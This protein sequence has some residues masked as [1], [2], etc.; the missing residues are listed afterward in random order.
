MQDVTDNVTDTIEKPPRKI[1]CFLQ[2]Q[3]FK[4]PE[5]IKAM[6]E[7][8]EHHETPEE[9]R[10]FYLKTFLFFGCHTGRMLKK[11]FGEELCQEIVWEEQSPILGGNANSKF[12]AD[13]KHIGAVLQRHQPTH[14]IAL[15]TMAKEALTLM[16]MQMSVNWILLKGPHPAARG[17]GILALLQ[18]LAAKL[19]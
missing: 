18:D 8:H 12:P 13:Y 19:K 3:W 2:N 9:C 15:G 11:A 6:I 17:N 4:N 16:K 7:K 1:V 10:E 14:V 5:R